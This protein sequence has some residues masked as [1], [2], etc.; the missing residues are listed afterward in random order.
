MKAK[1]LVVTSIIAF[2]LSFVA[3]AC[4]SV[5]SKPMQSTLSTRVVKNAANTNE[6]A[7][8]DDELPTTDDS[9]LFI[10]IVNATK[11]NLGESFTIRFSANTVLYPVG[12]TGTRKYPQTTGIYVTPND[13]SYPADK[14]LKEL[15]KYDV[16][17]SEVVA[18]NGNVE[19][20]KKGEDGN[21][22]MGE[23]GLY[24]LEDG[25]GYSF[26]M[27][28]YNAYVSRIDAKNSG[29]NGIDTIV[30]PY[31]ITYGTWFNLR[32]TEFGENVVSNT[33]T[34]VDLYDGIKTIV[35]GDNIE[36][37]P[38]NALQDAPADLVVKT[39][40]AELPGSWNSDFTKATVQYSYNPTDTEREIFDT[41]PIS[42]RDSENVEH[43]EYYDAYGELLDENNNYIDPNTK[44][45]IQV[46]NEDGDLVNKVFD[47]EAKTKAR[48]FEFKAGNYKSQASESTFMI[49]CID[50]EKGFNLP[51]LLK[52]DVIK[53]DGSVEK[54]RVFE[55]PISTEGEKYDAIGSGSGKYSID[56]DIDIVL[57]DGESIDE[58]SF[59]F[60]NIFTAVSVAT[61]EGSYV[62]EPV[63][64]E[65][66]RNIPSIT[67]SSKIKI[68]DIFSIKYGS[69]RTVFGYTTIGLK[70]DLVDGIYA[71]V[72]TSTYKSYESRILNGEYKVRYAFRDLS[73]ADY[74]FE[75]GDNN[76]ITL[77]VCDA[78]GQ[79]PTDLDYELFKK[80]KGNSLTFVFNNKKVGNGINAYN[81]KRAKLCAFRVSLDLC[82]TKK[83]TT[84][85]ATKSSI[86]FRF[87]Y[88]DLLPENVDKV[89]KF[90]GDVFLI[91]YIIAFL[92]LYI[93]G[94]IAY[95]FYAR[96]KYK[97]DEFRRIN[98]KAYVKRMS[99]AFVGALLI[100]GAN[101]FITLRFFIV[102]QS[103]I[104]FNPLDPLVVVFGVGG[105]ISIGFFIKFL[106]VYIKQVKERRKIL[107][108]K[109]NE[110]VEDDGTK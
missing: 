72:K 74:Y 14:T 28:S 110:D 70:I 96:S 27:P 67:I 45:I 81:L 29:K 106:V 43:I 25:H 48:A 46:E 101:L 11:T 3:G 21:P 89:A 10:S 93:G 79:I 33:D 9:G 16:E 19:N 31:S 35:I 44:Q 64:G 42:Y 82:P 54:D 23:N 90:N 56:K 83:G 26:E 60:Y 5:A 61:P 57:A 98:G 91:I 58:T 30:I 49:G 4:L 102:N 62:L 78:A 39:T 108:L 8:I 65:A 12:T 2:A 94:S 85:I 13:E 75:Y 86:S 36:K 77:N 53:A 38:E 76:S 103:L 69:I 88:I 20:V 87:G 24:V 107:K 18:A 71:K 47:G 99:K 55:C 92:A 80:S 40:Y 52:Y 41:R 105:L 95:Y 17:L 1:R 51:L 84:Q 73:Q 100:A 7:H 104:V 34:S 97:N 109:L 66:F 15:T 6:Y 22:V 59:K 68:E 63:V 50:Q 37:I 32:V